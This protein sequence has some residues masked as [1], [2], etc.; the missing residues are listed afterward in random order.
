[1]GEHLSSF[2]LHWSTWSQWGFGIHASCTWGWHH[3]MGR[4]C[5]VCA[6][7][8]GDVWT[9]DAMATS[10]FLSVG[11]CI[12]DHLSC[13]FTLTL[14]NCLVL[15]VLCSMCIVCSHSI[16]NSLIWDGLLFLYQDDLLTF[17]TNMHVSKSQEVMSSH[18]NPKHLPW[19]HDIISFMFNCVKHSLCQFFTHQALFMPNLHTHTH[20]YPRSLSIFLAP[21]QG[22]LM[23]ALAK[24][25]WKTWRNVDVPC[26]PFLIIP[27]WRHRRT[28]SLSEV[29]ANAKWKTLG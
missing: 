29:G 11:S 5:R 19:L 17:L 13:P 23:I 22:I 26:C 1:M 28:A 6:L 25:W 18:K 12:Q 7:R 10:W 2:Y 21:L 27:A 15:G 3:P 4:Q 16:I 8:N 20:T 24:S 14:H 9:D